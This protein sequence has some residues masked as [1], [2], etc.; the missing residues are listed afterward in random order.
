MVMDK[1]KELAI[2][3]LFILSNSLDL[4]AIELERKLSLELN[5]LRIVEE[6]FLG[7]NLEFSGFKRENKI[8]YFFQKMAVAKQNKNSI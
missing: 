3:Q 4:N 1:S 5:E 6:S 7:R 8:S 2:V